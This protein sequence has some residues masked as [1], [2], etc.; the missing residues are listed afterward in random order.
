MADGDSR[1]TTDRR[2][3]P[4]RPTRDEHVVYSDRVRW[5]GSVG[6]DHLVDMQRMSIS[7]NAWRCNS[8]SAREIELA[9]NWHGN[10]IGNGKHGVVYH[11]VLLD[12]KRVAVKELLNNSGS[13]EEFIEEVE[14]IWCIRHKNLVK[15][16]GYSINGAK[17]MLVY[18]YINN[19]NLQQWLHGTLGRVSPLTWD[20]R[21][22]IILGIAKGLVY[23]HE[24]SEPTVILKRLK[25]S[26]ILL[27]HQ[28]N[29]RLSNIGITRLLA[30][31]PNQSVSGMSGY[32]APEYVVTHNFNEKSDIYSF[33]VLIIEIVSGKAPVEYLESGQKEYLVEWL[34]EMVSDEMFDEILDPKLIQEPPS[35]KELK[36]VTLIALR[37]VDHDV[38]NR[39]TVGDVIHMLE[40]RDLLLDD[41]SVIDM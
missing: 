6:R 9:T 4:R 41:D 5:S 13:V 7:S 31:G 17:R 35:L 24:D 30:L 33:G 37:C 25:S 19:G 32:V 38:E 10:V 23:L 20:I 2:Y 40:P 12:G 29:P 18:E 39:P 14:A 26:H 27:D 16:L 28:W 36:R 1:R 3:V 15:L 21:M 34:K 11:G 22:S 8:Y